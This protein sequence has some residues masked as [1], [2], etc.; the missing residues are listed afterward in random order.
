MSRRVRVIGRPDD[1]TGPRPAVPSPAVESFLAGD[2]VSAAPPRVRRM[3][4]AVLRFGERCSSADATPPP[5]SRPKRPK[6]R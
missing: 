6:E 5:A 3:L 4:A 1:G 2:A